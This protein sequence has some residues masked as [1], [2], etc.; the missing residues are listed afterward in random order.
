[1]LKETVLQSVYNLFKAL[2]V[3]KIA[4]IRNANVM[5]QQMCSNRNTNKTVESHLPITAVPAQLTFV[6]ISI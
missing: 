5:R 4:L 3:G 2:L 6:I 1:M